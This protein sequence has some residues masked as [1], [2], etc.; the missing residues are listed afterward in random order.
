V[1]GGASAWLSG[2]MGVLFSL[3]GRVVRLAL[4]KTIE[5][6][7]KTTSRPGS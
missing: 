7:R 1:V 5:L 3:P 6:E 2:R 4:E